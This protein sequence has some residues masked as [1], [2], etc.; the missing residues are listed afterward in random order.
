MISQG[1]SEIN[2]SC[3]IEGKDV[4]KVL[5]LIHQS[6]LKFNSLSFVLFWDAGTDFGLGFFCRWCV[7]VD[8]RW[9]RDLVCSSQE[10]L[11]LAMGLFSWDCV[12]GLDRLYR[13]GWRTCFLLIILLPLP[14]STY[15]VFSCSCALEFLGWGSLIE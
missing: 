4:V 13:G 5:N 8:L 11:G 7:G 9:E 2:I 12:W 14:Q 1:A 10:V 15:C 6:C 3:V